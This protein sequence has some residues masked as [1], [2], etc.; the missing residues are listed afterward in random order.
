MSMPLKMTPIDGKCCEEGLT[1]AEDFIRHT[2]VVLA[3][4]R[5]VRDGGPT[6]QESYNESVRLFCPSCGTYYEVPVELES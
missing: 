1:L 2:R 3:G 6:E 5:W 4:T